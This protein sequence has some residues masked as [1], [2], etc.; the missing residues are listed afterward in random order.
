MMLVCYKAAHC[1]DIMAAVTFPTL[2]SLSQ[3][4]AHRDALWNLAAV[5]DA[6][7]REAAK[8]RQRVR[9]DAEQVLALQHGRAVGVGTIP[10]RQLQPLS[11]ALALPVLCTCLMLIK[12]SV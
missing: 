4:S 10:L 11:A 3:G 8:V 7:L 2:K 9:V 1:K 5:E 12:L 6:L